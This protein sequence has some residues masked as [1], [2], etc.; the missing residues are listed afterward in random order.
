[1]LSSVVSDEYNVL[2][3]PSAVVTL[4]DLQ[5]GKAEDFPLLMV[6]ICHISNKE[7]VDSSYM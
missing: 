2:S 7:N 1:M 3:F 6:W 4:K 5:A